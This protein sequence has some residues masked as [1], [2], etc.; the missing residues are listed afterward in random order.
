MACGRINY[1]NLEHIVQATSATEVHTSVGASAAFAT[2]NGYDRENGDGNN[3]IAE[4]LAN[5][6]IFEESVRKLVSLLD[7]ISKRTPAS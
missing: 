4:M 1:E 3:R 6:K 7:T 2:G 5:T